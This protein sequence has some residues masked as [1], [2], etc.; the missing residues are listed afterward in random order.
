MAEVTS[1]GLVQMTRKRVP[2]SCTSQAFAVCPSIT[3]VTLRENFV[4]TLVT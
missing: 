2:Q 4:R 1:M 3:V